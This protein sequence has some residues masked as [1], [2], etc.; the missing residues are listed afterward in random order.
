M[1]NSSRILTSLLCGCL[2]YALLSADEMV[3]PVVPNAAPSNN[4][5]PLTAPTPESPPSEQPPPQPPAPPQQVVVPPPPAPKEC[6]PVTQAYPHRLQAKQTSGKGIGYNHGYSTVE[7]FFSPWFC[8]DKYFPFIDLKAHR[9]IVGKYAG[10]AGIGLRGYSPTRKSFWGIYTYYDYRQTH[11][12]NYK[13]ASL[14]LEYLTLH[15]DWR[16]NGYYPFGVKH[17]HEFAM[18]G[19]DTEMAFHW[20]PGK[21]L[22]VTTALGPYYFHGD[23]SKYAVGGKARAKIELWN[24]LSFEGNVS[25]DNLF[26]WIGQGQVSLTIP[27][28]IKKVGSTITKSDCPHAFTL[29]KRQAQ[30]VERQE[31]IVTRRHRS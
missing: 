7:L 16:I 28:G 2:A 25:Y 3:S 17:Q 27:L 12:K 5:N 13:Q 31:I 22:E 6:L 19:V 29:G 8:F 30:P 14:G 10:N 23:D 1:M 24:L 18:P 4:P 20:N 21:N 15:W 9:F 11:D 26:K